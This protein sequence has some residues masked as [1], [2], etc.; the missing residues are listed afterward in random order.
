MLHLSQQ[1]P[2]RVAGQQLVMPGHNS[3]LAG[4]K[5]WPT[6]CTIKP[7]A[8]T[9]SSTLTC[10]VVLLTSADAP[11]HAA[12]HKSHMLMV[13]PGLGYDAVPFMCSYLPDALQGSI[14]YTHAN[15]VT[16]AVI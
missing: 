12:P 3:S 4:S 6:M 8:E 7:V 16:D 13:K 15:R 14:L 11:H 9:L 1:G 10:T 2:C 5:V